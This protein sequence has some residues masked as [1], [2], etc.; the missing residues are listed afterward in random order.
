MQIY[1]LSDCRGN[2]N[3]SFAPVDTIPTGSAVV[4][5]FFDG[6]HLGHAELIR[7]AKKYADEHRTS[8]TVWTFESMPKA[9]KV[10]TTPDEKISVLSS[11]GVDYALL[12][13]FFE[14]QEM[15]PD[16]FFD[17][18]LIKKL[19]PSA[20]FFG[21]NFRYGK[22]AAGG[23]G[24]LAESAKAHG[25]DSFT[26]LPYE[27]NGLV[28]SSSRIRS[29]ILDGKLDEANAL[30]MHP[31]SVSGKVMRGNRIGHTIGFPTLNLRLP[32]EKIPAK[33]GV[34]ASIAIID[35][36]RYK[37]V[38]NLGS[39]P[40]VNGDTNDVTLET[41]IFDFEREFY[42]DRLTVEF[43]SFIRKEKRFSSVDELSAQIVIDSNK[44]KEL[45]LQKN[46]NT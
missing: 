25:I 22:N 39:R 16:T 27:K 10:I 30:L 32:K 9:E 45:L 11:L 28:V 20:L 38:S 14:V 46:K 42:G 21:F 23:A 13:D 2:E 15:T 33:N 24:T 3:R 34:Y 19:A 40:T 26:M 4:L 6:V 44:A 35:G 43:I 7:S 1:R 31:Y 36:K 5:G 8:V 12:E 18:Y 37:A 29:L 17:D 41:H